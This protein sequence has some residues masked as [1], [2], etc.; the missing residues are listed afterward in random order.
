MPR[1]KEVTLYSFDELDEAAKE[2]AREWFREG[3]LDYDWWDFTY[4]DAKTIGKLMGIDITT[5][6]FSG[7]WS[8][9]DGAC[10]VGNYKYQT[11]SVK[12]VK[13]YAPQDQ[14][15][16]RIATGLRDAQRRSFYRLWA[17]CSHSVHYYHEGCMKVHVEDNDRP[18]DT[19]EDAQEAITELLR[20]FARWIY[21]RLEEEYEW[22]QADEQVD[23]S[24]RVNEYE[25]EE[26]GS[27]A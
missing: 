18:Y 13:D 26:D 27:R 19:S 5:I 22:L 15:L 8:Q 23:E 11:G 4:E 1:I 20:D 25:F 12:A 3:N 7:F 21:R 2:K 6:Y 16:H 24:I 9:G 10:F 14:E 17:A